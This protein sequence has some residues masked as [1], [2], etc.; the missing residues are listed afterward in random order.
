MLVD[1]KAKT[2]RLELKGDMTDDETLDVFQFVMSDCFRKQVP[3]DERLYAYPGPPRSITKLSSGVYTVSFYNENLAGT[4][5]TL[6][7][8]DAPENCQ[9]SVTLTSNWI[10][11]LSNDLF[12]LPARP[13]TALAGRIGV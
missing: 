4:G 5:F 13:V 12:N 2:Y 1:H 10:A 3:Y 6:R 11:A 8:T 7:T 9:Y